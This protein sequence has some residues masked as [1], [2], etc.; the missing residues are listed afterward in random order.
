[1]R[2]I[3]TRGWAAQY[4]RRRTAK[5]SR[6]CRARGTVYNVAR[7]GEL[8]LLYEMAYALAPAWFGD[9]DFGC[10]CWRFTAPSQ[11]LRGQLG[12]QRHARHRYGDEP[13]DRQD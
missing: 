2:T 4:P 11:A 8:R 6:I 1:M 10:R 12:G 7:G 5:R 3:V 9:D 13:G